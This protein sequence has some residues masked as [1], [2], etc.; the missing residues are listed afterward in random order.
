[1][2][3][4]IKIIIKDKP[5]LLANANI[6]FDTVAFGSITIKNFAIWKSKHFN[7]RLQEAIN[8]T[9]PSTRGFKYTA[10]V[11]FENRDR[12]YELEQQIYDAFNVSRQN[13]QDEDI[14]PDDVDVGIETLKQE[15]NKRNDY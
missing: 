12:W 13:P 8:I 6:S 10:I 11:F 9:P 1:M 3:I 2:D 15:E 5:N 4:K 14:D 7:E